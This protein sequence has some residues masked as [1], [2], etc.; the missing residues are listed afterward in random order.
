MQSTSYSLLLP[1][2]S[3]SYS[4]FPILIFMIN[5][6][7]SYLLLAASFL[8]Q[9]TSYLITIFF[10]GFP[11]PSLAETVLEKIQQTGV[12]KAG[13]R[14]DA[15]PFS[16]INSQ[17][18]QLEGYSVELIKLI[19]QRLEQE[20][21]KPIKLELQKIS[22]EERFQLIEDGKLDIVC[23]ATTINNAREEVVD[24]SIPFF[25]TGIQL[26][27]KKTDAERFD[28]IK[29]TREK[30]SIGLLQ[31][32]TTEEEFRPIYPNANW[33]AVS[34]RAEGINELSQGK[35]DAIASDGIL[36]LGAV[37]QQN[38]NFNEFDLIP[39]IPFTFE[40]YGCILPLANS[41]WDK[42]VDTTIASDEN[43]QLLHQW[44]DP[45]KGKFPYESF[46]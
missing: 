44:F 14:S 29:G 16:Y 19:H 13:V 34:D 30:I 8:N 25:T 38:K 7:S 1:I 5:S 41:D 33:Q 2:Q 27:V 18:N 15:V 20:L 4:L 9:I 31:G 24:F 22:L 26:L 17:T 32:T 28:P 21:G 46:R 10:I 11:L 6:S 3:T 40:N 39:K 12:L 23:A 37:W 35:I 42:F 43:T 36:L 45:K